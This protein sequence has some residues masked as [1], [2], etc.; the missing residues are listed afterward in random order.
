MLAKHHLWRLRFDSATSIGRAVNALPSPLGQIPLQQPVSKLSIDDTGS[1]QSFRRLYEDIHYDNDPMYEDKP[2]WYPSPGDGGER[3]PAPDPLRLHYDKTETHDRIPQVFAAL[4][5]I[6]T[7]SLT[8]PLA[9]ADYDGD[10]RGSGDNW[11]DCYVLTALDEIATTFHDAFTNSPAFQHVTDLRLQVPSTHYIGELANALDM[12]ARTRLKHLQVVIMDQTGSCG[13]RDFSSRADPNHRDDM[14]DGVI[15]DDPEEEDEANFPYSNVQRMYPNRKHQ[16][17]LWA[18]VRCCHNLE[19]LYI[20]GSHFLDL[21]LLGW[22]TATDS[23][24]QGL[25]VLALS[26]V[27]VSPDSLLD[28]IRPHPE[29]QGTSRLCRISLDDVKMR[30][31]KWALVFNYL[32]D[33]CSD[34]ECGKF[35]NLTYFTEHE[36]YEHNN[37]IHENSITVQRVRFASSP[38]KF[39]RN[40]FVGG[41]VTY[42]GCQYYDAKVISPLLQFLD[43]EYE[44]LSTNEKKK[45]DKELEN[46]D[47]SIFFPM[48]FTTAQV[49]SPPYRSSDPEWAQYTTISKDKPLLRRIRNELA[50]QAK[51]V[52]EKEPMLNPRYRNIMRIRQYWLDIDFPPRPPPT[53]EQSGILWDGNGL[54]WAARTIDS[55]KATRLHNILW[56][57]AAAQASWAYASAMAKQHWFQFQRLLGFDVPPPSGPFSQP[58]TA[59]L[60]HPKFPSAGRQ[61]PDGRPADAPSGSGKGSAGMQPPSNAPSGGKTRFSKDDDPSLASNVPQMSTVPFAEFLIKLDRT[62]GR[63]RPYPPRGSIQ[64]SGIV[65]LETQTS[66]ILLDVLGFW[67][68]KKRALDSKSSLFSLRR[69]KM[70]VQAAA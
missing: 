59:A 60:D 54:H 22:S 38:R 68:P 26:R 49:W 31:G 19:A 3:H 41:C 44:S 64:V 27:Y 39:M 55:L 23:K 2:V 20:Q 16:E 33:E 13:N 42:L 35:F 43:R 4:N 32:N 1:V 63:A 30:E 47:D 62:W 40:V 6:Q 51:D 50:L 57:T 21:D 8:L 12:E 58:R 10:W 28:L 56:P 70:K 18:F 11:A 15:D 67:D 37:R 65:E 7:F 14:A 48:P 69:I 24:W 66:Y 61:T 9:E 45:L 29:V 25:Q 46:F 52:V 5:K 36:S 17:A 53:F 34:L